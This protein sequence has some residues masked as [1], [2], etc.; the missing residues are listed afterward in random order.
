MKTKTLLTSSAFLHNT[1]NDSDSDSETEHTS[2][3]RISSTIIQTPPPPPRALPP[4]LTSN[5]SPRRLNR[6][7]S[8]SL[9][10]QVS[11]TPSFR[12][13]ETF[14]YNNNKYTIRYP[15]QISLPYNVTTPPLNITIAS[16]TECLIG[17][18]TVDLVL[19]SKSSATDEILVWPISDKM[20]ITIET[21]TTE[22][23]LKAARVKLALEHSNIDPS[24]GRL[25]LPVRHYQA[26]QEA[27]Q[28][29]AL[30][31]AL[32][33][34][35]FN[36]MFQQLTHP[37]LHRMFSQQL[38]TRLQFESSTTN[39]MQDILTRFGPIMDQALEPDPSKAFAEFREDLQNLTDQGR[40]IT[41]S[42]MLDH[43]CDFYAIIA[44]GNII[45]QHLYR[46]QTQPLPPRH[47]PPANKKRKKDLSS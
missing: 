18:D 22:P 4:C 42:E 36:T 23:K 6:T 28:K 34:T 13:N 5:P 46:D 30:K 16:Y 37:G 17:D 15:P 26:K 47:P 14:H 1:N 24:T 44:G 35:K 21:N 27:A 12:V 11:A 32:T 33:S 40:T 9:T 38:E 2:R 43:L 39:V 19:L 20:A 31:K 25:I 3:R 10:R 7:P 8:T 45:A 41:P 29:I